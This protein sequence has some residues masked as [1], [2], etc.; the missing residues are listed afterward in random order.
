[1]LLMAEKYRQKEYGS[2]DGAVQRGALSKLIEPI[3]T[4]EKVLRKSQNIPND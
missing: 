2:E 1:M 4:W 3:F